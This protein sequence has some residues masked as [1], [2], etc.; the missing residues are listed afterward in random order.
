ML[1]DE[2]V[3]CKR[4][5]PVQLHSLGVSKGDGIQRVENKYFRTYQHVPQ[6]EGYAIQIMRL[7]G[8]TVKVSMPT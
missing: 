2:K 8:S 5:V 6:T 7:V 1:S 4:K 3:H